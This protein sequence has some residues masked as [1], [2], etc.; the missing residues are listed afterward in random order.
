MNGAHQ[1]L[2]L[3]H[4][5]LFGISFGLL[6][7]IWSM[8]RKSKDVRW[9]AVFLFVLAGIAGWIVMETGESAEEIVEQLPGVTKALIHD[10]EEAAEFANISAT[11]LAVLALLMEFVAYYRARL[12][13][14][15]QYVVL[16]VAVVSSIAMARTA[17]LGGHVRHTEIRSDAEVPQELGEES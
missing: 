7:L 13:K 17:F 3:N 15:T 16:L 12:L 11:V 1:H 10:H 4:I 6:I 5:P 2:L 9:A 8:L 14:V